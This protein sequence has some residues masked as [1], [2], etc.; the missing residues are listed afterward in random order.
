M[1]RSR[2]G[3]LVTITFGGVLVLGALTAQRAL[4]GATAGTVFGTPTASGSAGASSVGST[5]SGSP[6]A[7]IAPSSSAATT[8]TPAPTATASPTPTAEPSP[9]L[10]ISPLD[11]LLVSPELAARHP[12]AVMVDDLGPARPQSGFSGASV[13]WQAPAEG[14]IPRY[15]MVFGS[16]TPAAVGPVRSARHYFIAWAAE[17]RAAY[18]HA[19]GS[20]QA[21]QTLRAQ[22]YG[23]LV[24]NAD[25]FFNGSSFWRIAE[26]ASP[27]NLYTDDAHLQALANKIGATEPPKG[28]VWKFGPDARLARRP[29][30]GRI[31]VV[32]PANTIRYTYDRL[33]NTYPRSVSREKEQIDAATGKRVAPKNVVI[34]FMSFAPLN[35]GSTKHRLEAD[36]V[37]KG[38]AWIA[39]NGRTIKGTWRKNSLTAP[40]QFFDKAGKPV[41]LTAGQTFVQVVPIGTPVTIRSGRIIRRG[42]E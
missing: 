4:D 24:Y 31:E 41:T 17:W 29:V 9:V 40:T 8:P 36:V 25:Q 26:R 34:M 37:G 35:D 21:L 18:V 6:T 5:S 3:L 7:S 39:T 30:G 33:T 12:I 10:V 15:M 13:V 32:Y 2:I 42:L 19:G 11:G 20:P 23:Q 38:T 28:P 14:G 16:G 22:G 1:T 27:H